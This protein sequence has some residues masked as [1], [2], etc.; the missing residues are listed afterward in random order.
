MMAVRVDDIKRVSELLERYRKGDPAAVLK[1]SD[2]AN[3][4][5]DEGE[6]SGFDM[7]EEEEL[8]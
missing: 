7:I 4:G 6:D 2:A 3:S 5:D 1:E 8:L